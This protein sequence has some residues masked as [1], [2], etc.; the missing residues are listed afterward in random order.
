MKTKE[1]T[2]KN[3]EVSIKAAVDKQAIAPLERWAAR[4]GRSLHK[5]AGFLLNE[6]TKLMNE[7]PRLLVELGLMTSRIKSSAA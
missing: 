4:E 5:H 1:T 6:L 2:M 3:N 7:E